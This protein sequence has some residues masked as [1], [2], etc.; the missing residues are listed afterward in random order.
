M[1]FGHGPVTAAHL[2]KRLLIGH[3][4][5]PRQDFAAKPART[6]AEFIGKAGRCHVRD[7]S[8]V[9]VNSTGNAFTLALFI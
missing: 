6:R 3:F 5:L 2:V 7:A 1:R 9:S 4:G 8:T